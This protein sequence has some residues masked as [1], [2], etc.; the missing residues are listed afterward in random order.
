MKAFVL[1]AVILSFLCGPVSAGV[2]L[3]E[4]EAKLACGMQVVDL[5]RQ[6][7]LAYVNG[8]PEERVQ[9]A[10]SG[11]SRALEL[12]REMVSA[13][14]SGNKERIES[15]I[16]HMFDECVTFYTTQEV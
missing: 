2:K 1:S 3:P 10:L 15:A 9:E 4:D 14:Y 8:V 5:A 11:Q 13:I 7:N 6:I 16:E 12:G